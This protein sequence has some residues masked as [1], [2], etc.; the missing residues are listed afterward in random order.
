M[1]GFC[2]CF[3]FSRGFQNKFFEVSGILTEVYANLKWFE[4]L[5]ELLFRSIT[6]FNI[7]VK[8]QFTH[9]IINKLKKDKELI[10]EF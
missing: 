4:V 8:K 9:L 5:I 7:F 3:F 1:G 2:F 10:V 6:A